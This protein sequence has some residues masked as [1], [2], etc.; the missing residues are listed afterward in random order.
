VTSMKTTPSAVAAAA[1]SM[2]LTGESYAF[3]SS[4]SSPIRT[5]AICTCNDSSGTLP[6]CSSGA[7]ITPGSYKVFALTDV[8]AT[9]GIII[10]VT[11]LDGSTPKLA[12][13]LNLNS[14]PDVTQSFSTPIH[15]GTDLTVQCSLSGPGVV[16]VDGVLTTPH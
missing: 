6:H 4:Q 1:L 11:L 2:A 3:L 8:T 10:D 9:T 7:L 14:A 16:T 13:A 15:F 12:Y 5:S